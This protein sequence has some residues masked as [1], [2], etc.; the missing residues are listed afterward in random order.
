VF[1][2]EE[3]KNPIICKHCGICTKFCPHECLTLEE[4]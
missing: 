1:F 3:T 2:D 4:K